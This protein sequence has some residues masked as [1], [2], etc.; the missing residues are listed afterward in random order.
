MREHGGA[1]VLNPSGNVLLQNFASPEGKGGRENMQTFNNKS[2]F[3]QK[4]LKEE[5]VVSVNT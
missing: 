5:I 1:I 2:E 4:S 3:Q